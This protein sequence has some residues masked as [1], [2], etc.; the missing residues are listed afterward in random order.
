MI[1]FTLLGIIC[2]ETSKVVEYIKGRKLLPP[3]AD[4]GGKLKVNFSFKVAKVND[5]NFHVWKQ[6][7]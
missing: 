1:A 6:C 4:T 3:P 2:Y 5:G 7:V